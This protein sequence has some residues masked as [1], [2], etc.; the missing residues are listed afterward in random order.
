MEGLT[1]KN[2]NTGKSLWVALETPFLVWWMGKI[3]ILPEDQVICQLGDNQ[4]VLVDLNTSQIG[5]IT[6]GKGPVVVLEE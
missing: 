1:G 5:L 3:T 4:I 6:F 2:K